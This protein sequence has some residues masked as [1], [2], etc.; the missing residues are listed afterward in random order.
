MEATT[1]NQIERKT[2][3]RSDAHA[4]WGTGTPAEPVGT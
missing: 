4:D 1:A 2:G 3:F